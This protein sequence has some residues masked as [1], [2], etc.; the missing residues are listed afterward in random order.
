MT[1]T[2]ALIDK[3]EKLCE[4]APERARLVSKATV[5]RV[6]SDANGT[7][8]G[9]EYEKDGKKFTE[10]GA[11]ILATGGFGA[12]F[13]ES[14]L[15]K[16]YSEQWRSLS[17][18]NDVPNLPNLMTLPTTN[19]EHCTGDGIK[20]ALSLGADTV[21]MEAV[22]VHPTGLVHPDEPDAKVKF[23]AAEALRGVGGLL[24]NGK[25]ERFCDEL[26]KR[27]YV[28]GRMWNSVGPFRLILNSKASNEIIWHCKHYMGRGLMKHYKNGA[29]LAK[30]MG[31][32]PQKL[33][34]EY[35][36]YNDIAD[37]KVCPFGK[38][39]F[40]NTPFS[41]DDE[42]HVAIVTPVVH[43]TMG[44]L[45][46]NADSEVIS[47]KGTAIPGLYCAGEVMGGVHG[48]NRL[49]GN[50]LLDCVA[51]G[52]VAGQ[53][54]ARFLLQHHLKAVR[55]GS[56]GRLANI[57]G[58][59]APINI[60]VDPATSRVTIDINL[61]GGSASLSAPTSSLPAETTPGTQESTAA[62]AAAAAPAPAADATFS[63]A[64]VAKHNTDSDC[65]VVV[66]GEVLNVT[67]FLNDHPGGKKAIMLYAGKDASEEFNM[68]HKPDVVKKYAPECIIG[69]LAN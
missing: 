10:E 20:M 5:T 57:A 63:L 39:F 24:L 15:L 60:S 27:D 65:W 62:P 61:N 17:A 38:K 28:S 12:D 19:G 23:L 48:K 35:E 3:F 68:L 66:N 11:V 4:T 67:S 58:H 54:A 33:Q 69:K 8:I 45:K 30:D 64:E 41:M 43:Y 55:T 32:T 53:S 37:K 52:R 6:V 18:W 16:K 44:G 34:S 2:Y 42:F 31:I 26:G 47:T 21:D 46:I 9:V 49:G 29:E 14:S 56:A 25:G 59:L 50:S 40:Q 13:S 1:I 7:A 22:Q 36:K 51:F